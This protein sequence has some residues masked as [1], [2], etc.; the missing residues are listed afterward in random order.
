MIISRRP[1]HRFEGPPGSLDR[2]IID[3]AVGYQAE[4]PLPHHAHLHTLFNQPGS[5]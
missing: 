4:S 1:Q 5:E 2:R 3:P